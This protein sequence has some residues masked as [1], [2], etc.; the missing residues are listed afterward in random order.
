[1]RSLPTLPFA[2]SLL[3][4]TGCLDTGPF[5]HPDSHTGGVEAGGDCSYPYD[6]QEMLTCDYD[7]ICTDNASFLACTDFNNAWSGPLNPST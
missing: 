4:V 2:V 3:L 5:D 1:M 6:C 7:G